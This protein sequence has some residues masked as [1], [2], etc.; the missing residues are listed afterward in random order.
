M[1]FSVCDDFHILLYMKRIFNGF[2]LIE[3]LVVVLIIGILAAIAI[4]QYQKT[5][6]KSRTSQAVLMVKAITDAQERYYLENGAYTNNIPDLDIIVPPEL[7]T[8][9]P[10]GSSIGAADASRPNVYI[11]SCWANRT[12]GAVAGSASMP[13]IEFTMK[14]DPTYKG[15]HWCQLVPGKNSTAKSICQT[16]GP[17]DT[18]YGNGSYFLIN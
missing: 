4:P 13:T 7:I 5:V 2:T 11:Y 17:V 9:T 6:L 1:F 14:Y 8:T 12:C 10:G 16:M 15:K 3:L 18:A